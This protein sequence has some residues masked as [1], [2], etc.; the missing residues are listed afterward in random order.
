MP[1]HAFPDMDFYCHVTV[2]RNI[3]PYITFSSL[4]NFSLTQLFDKT[5]TL[6]CKYS[7]SFFVLFCELKAAVVKTEVII[8]S[9]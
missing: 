9:F 8:V 5:T 1:L 7:S 3:F 4:Q 6:H 2:Y